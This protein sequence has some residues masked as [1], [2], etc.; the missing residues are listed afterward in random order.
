MQRR[1]RPGV[2]SPW[3]DG[4]SNVP[5]PCC[6]LPALQA[7]IWSLRT[8]SCFPPDFKAATAELLRI[9]QKHGGCMR[10][11]RLVWALDCNMAADLLLPVLGRN[12]ADWL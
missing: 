1:S 8:H 5:A 7:G 12:P 2:G 9:S 11:G 3:L 4:P 10:G 6:P